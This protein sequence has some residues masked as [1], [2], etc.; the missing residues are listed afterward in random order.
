M[1][2]VRDSFGGDYED[3][4][5]MAERDS[6]VRISVTDADDHTTKQITESRT[7]SV[8]SIHSP[9]YGHFI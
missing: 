1:Y 8:Q 5:V 3:K 2:A 7:H 4:R 6:F 9:I